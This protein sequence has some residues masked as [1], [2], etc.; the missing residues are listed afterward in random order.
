[1]VDVRNSDPTSDRADPPYPLDPAHAAEEQEMNIF[2]IANN[3]QQRENTMKASSFRLMKA[4]FGIFAALAMVLG[5]TSYAAMTPRVAEAQQ[6]TIASKIRNISYIPG[7]TA[8]VTI[9]M[10]ADGSTDKISIDWGKTWPSASAPTVYVASLMKG[11]NDL[12]S[13][14]KSFTLD[15]NTGLL[16]LQ[17]TNPIEVANSDRLTLRFQWSVAQMIPR[18]YSTRST[19]YVAG[20]TTPTSTPPSNAP[21]PSTVTSDGFATGG[22]GRFVDQIQWMQWGASGEQVLAPNGTKTVSMERKVGPAATDIL[23]TTCTINNLRPER[24]SNTSV[25]IVRNPALNA[26]VPGSWAGDGLDNLYNVGG[27]NDSNTMSIGLVNNVDGRPSP[28]QAL[29]F[30]YSCETTLN[31]EPVPLSGLVLA[32]AEASSGDGGIRDEFIQAT[33]TKVQRG[34]TATW[35]M[36]DRYSTCSDSY[37]SATRY[38]DNTLRLTAQGEE[39]LYRQTQRDDQGMPYLNPQYAGPMTVA[40][41]EGATASHVHI[42]GRGKTAIALGVIVDTDFGDAPESY[43][44]AG[45]LFQRN[46]TGGTI[47]VNRPTNVSTSTFPLANR[48]SVIAPYLGNTEDSEKTQS[49]SDKAYGDD[50]DLTDDEDALPNNILKLPTELEVKPNGTYVVDRITCSGTRDTYVQ[51]WIDWNLNGLF[52]STEGSDVVP[53]NGTGKNISLTYR[54]PADTQQSLTT[55]FMRLRITNSSEMSPTGMTVAGE[56]EDYRLERSLIR[57][58]KVVDNQLGGIAKPEDWQLKAGQYSANP[59]DN[60]VSVEGKQY[61]P[62]TPG[63]SL[64]LSEEAINS[65]R[66]KGYELSQL[67]CQVYKPTWLGNKW[68]FEAEGDPTTWNGQS[69][70]TA[71]VTPSSNTLTECKFTNKQVSLTLLFRK[72]GIPPYE[73]TPTPQPLKGA[74]FV[75]YYDNEGQIGAPLEDLKLSKSADGTSWTLSKLTTG[76]YW[77][78]ETK[79]PVGYNLLA[80]P[81]KFTIANTND[82]PRV[83]VADNSGGL[84]TA[85][86]TKLELVAQNIPDTGTLPRTGGTGLIVPVALASLLIA[87]GFLLMRRKF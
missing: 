65:G 77:V 16:T 69:A 29:S 37:T 11:R 32:D 3:H 79:S 47:P 23:K 87:A 83:K 28:G 70:T 84:V 75:F 42:Q 33:P 31:G 73:S 64:A 81:V 54:M 17:L 19:V 76:D 51:G 20:A 57:L 15:T 53:C 66:V 6:T 36:I 56:V 82:G 7:S 10:E 41:L 67:T 22:R 86:D 1:M 24:N 61:I 71:S 63:T 30:D 13:N 26:Y 48:D 2:R 18:D 45:S 80:Q 34:K 12:S 21:L 74:E 43:Q 55:S 40:F 46:W 39:C 85:D 9:D 60:P 14:I 68:G 38:R 50:N 72:V 5:V 4:T 25:P 49:Y 62:V 8:Q 52:D 78:V 27:E 58:K 35:R 44:S 59:A